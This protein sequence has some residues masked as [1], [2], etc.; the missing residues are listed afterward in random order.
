MTDK[1]PEPAPGVLYAYMDESNGDIL[2]SAYHPDHE[3]W[4]SNHVVLKEFGGGKVSK[5]SHSLNIIRNVMMQAN[6]TV[7]LL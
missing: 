1:I 6:V 3:D 7:I 4:D 5:H 2:L